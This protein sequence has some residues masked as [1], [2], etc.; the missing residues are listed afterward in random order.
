MTR[1]WVEVGHG[2][3]FKCGQGR[4]HYGRSGVRRYD[5]ATWG[6]RYALMKPRYGLEPKLAKFGKTSRICPSERPNHLA[7]V[8]AYCSHAVV[9]MRRPAPRS[10]AWLTPTIG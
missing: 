7:S 5:C 8:P 4:P 1:I 10:F 3:G 6:T 2:F 9:G